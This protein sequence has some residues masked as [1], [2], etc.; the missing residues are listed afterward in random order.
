MLYSRS[1]RETSED[2]TRLY[3][4]LLLGPTLVQEPCHFKSNASC[5]RLCCF[6]CQVYPASVY[7]TALVHFT[8]NDLFNRKLRYF[9]LQLGF[10]LSEYGLFPVTKIGKRKV[11]RLPGVP[12]SVWQESEIKL[13]AEPEAWPRSSSLEVGNHTCARS[14]W[15]RKS[16]FRKRPMGRSVP[17]LHI[18]LRAILFSPDFMECEQVWKLAKTFTPFMDVEPCGVVDSL[19]LL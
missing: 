14:A 13:P 3:H 18:L 7:A 10:K 12:S 16:C 8:G 17:P 6:S 11:S 1:A 9:A 19:G 15:A 4:S 2:L 5:M